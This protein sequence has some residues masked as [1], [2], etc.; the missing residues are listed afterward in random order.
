[1]PAVVV[2]VVVAALYLVLDPPSADLAAQT[3]RVDLFDREGWIAWDNQWYGGHHLPGYSVL[4]PPLASLLGIE[5]VAALSLV[6]ATAAFARLAARWLGGGA[7]TAAAAW[8]AVGMAATLVSGRLA[9]ALGAAAGTAAMLAVAGGS[10]RWAVALGALTALASPVAALFLALIGAAVAVAAWG[11]AVAVAARG[12]DP[13]GKIRRTDS[14]GEQPESSRIY[15]GLAPLDAAATAAPPA[16]PAAATAAALAATATTAI[17][18]LAFPEGGTEPFVPSAFWP[19]LAAAAIAAAATKGAV[20]TGAL[21]YGLVLL[22]AFVVDNPLGGNA[23]R[24]GALLGGPL[25]VGLLWGRRRYLVALAAIPLAYWTAYPPARDWVQAADDPARAAAYYEPLLERLRAEGLGRLEIPF[26]EGH[27]ESARV[28]AHVPLA[29]GWERQLD[30]KVNAVFYEGELTAGRYRA[31]LDDNAIRWV[32]LHDAPLDYS[33]EAEAELVRDGLPYLREIW[34]DEHW[35][36]LAVDD[37]APLGATALGPDWFVTTGG[38]AKVRWTPYWAI[39]EGS[40]CVRRAAG[41]WT[42]VEPDPRGSQVRVAIRIS[43]ARALSG[44]PRC[45]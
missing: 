25:A 17:L 34:R 27:W 26:T 4:F 43:P 22:G 11:P 14:S 29:R 23:A 31:W 16:T 9:F 3:Y 32:A 5:V 21:L 12:S 38:V 39:V 10:K 6:A 18:V 28:A 7:A 1:M 33:A 36:L 42:A 45:R 2:A 40:G 15:A 19:A 35:R 20:R 13:L 24:L 30:R 41:D 8:F 37:P 44:G